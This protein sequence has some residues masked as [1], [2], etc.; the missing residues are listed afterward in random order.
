MNKIFRFFILIFAL[1]YTSSVS[2]Q[3]LKPSDMPAKEIEISILYDNYECM[4][5]TKTDWGFSCILEASGKRILF[6]TGTKPEILLN[7]A[8]V[9]KEELTEFDHIV[10][11]H[12]HHDHIGGLSTVLE[13]VKKV[14][15][16]IPYPADSK[17][18]TMVNELGSKHVSKVAPYEI[19]ENVW[20][21]GTM[22]D[23]I[24]EQCLVVNHEKGLVVITGCSH[25]GISDMLSQIKADF[26]KDI[27]A[28][29][30]GFHLM[31]HSKKNIGDIIN[32]F[33][34]LGIKK[35]GCTHCTGEKQIQQFRETY[36]ENFLEMGTGRRLII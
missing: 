24:H 18:E 2:A 33:N 21:S 30:G 15:V 17:V 11:S 22:G 13:G 20:S 1:S 7:N 34:D 31:M 19:A 10:I 29:M 12:Y 36:G 6:D 25:P 35:C 27:Y 8:G 26:G 16:H 5:G 9:I 4:E 14:P 23:Q 28:V 32:Q 3:I